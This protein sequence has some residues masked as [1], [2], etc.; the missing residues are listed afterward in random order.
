MLRTEL[1]RSFPTLYHVTAD[2]TWPS[3]R[4]LGLLSTEALVDRY[5]PGPAVRAEILDNRRRTNIRLDDP[6]LGPAVIRDQTPLKF[7]DRALLPG[8]T[9]RQYL[10]ALNSRVFFWLTEA[11]L[12]TLL[13]SRATRHL[14]QTVLWLSTSELLARH[15]DKV[16]LA[17]YNTGSIFVPTSPRRGTEVFVDIDSYDY[18]YWKARRRADAV[19]ELTVPYALP[20]TAELTIRVERWQHGAPVETLFER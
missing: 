4:R 7:L 11:R 5:Q 1:V 20:D 12:R 17:P 3:I 15:G 13:N 14:P 16:Q 2:G 19:V 10:H 9:P 18:A 6:E 8:T